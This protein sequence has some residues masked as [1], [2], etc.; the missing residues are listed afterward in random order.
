[1]AKSTGCRGGNNEM[2]KFIKIAII[3]FFVAAAFGFEY[4]IYSTGKL[5]EHMTFLEFLMLMGRR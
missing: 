3:L 5:Q 4:W 2:S 1:M